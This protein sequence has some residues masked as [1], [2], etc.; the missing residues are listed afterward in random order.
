[1]I[2][3]DDIDISIQPKGADNPTGVLAQSCNLSIQ[4][5]S[6]E[7]YSLG[8]VGPSAISPDGPA[9]ATL[10]INYILESENEPCFEI[11]RLLKNH[12]RKIVYGT[13]G[14]SGTAGTSGF[15]GPDKSKKTRIVFAGIT[16][17]YYLKGYTIQASPNSILTASA[18]FDCFDLVSGK[19]S[20][21]F[22]KKGE[23]PSLSFNESKSITHGWTTYLVE[24]GNHP[25]KNPTLNFNYSFEASH[26]P[27]Y[28]IGRQ[29]P[30]RVDFMAGKEKIDLVKLDFYNAH[31][32]GVT[33]E[34]TNVANS[35]TFSGNSFFAPYLLSCRNDKPDQSL[36][37]NLSGARITNTDI[38]VG[39]NDFPKTR[40]VAQK[41][42]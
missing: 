42:F 16:G 34:L 31:V 36:E 21:R 35:G 15:S 19:S 25:K 10:S 3:F 5:S 24:S 22:R 12:N 38:S 7:I 39:I 37:I 30:S 32:S 28:T 6:R 26:V 18:T 14:T 13:S 1:M 20:H 8:R 40:V 29:V 11:V 9:T 41:Y 23:T 4:N 17:D 33:G 2:Y 27:Q